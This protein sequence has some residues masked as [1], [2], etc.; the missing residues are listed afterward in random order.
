MSAALAAAPVENIPGPVAAV[1]F[2]VLCVILWW[3]WGT[4][5]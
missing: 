5:P 3:R 2:I 4:R 1:I